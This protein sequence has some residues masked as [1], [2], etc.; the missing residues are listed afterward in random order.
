MNRTVLLA[1]VVEL[2]GMRTTPAG[3]PALD[4]SLGHSS[5][6]SEAGHPRKVSLEMRAVAIGT[7]AERLKTLAVG[8]TAGF[9]G[10]LG[11]ARNGKGV[12]LHITDF[13][14]R[15]PQAL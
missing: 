4:L 14:P 6:V 2:G 5:Q 12:L 3:V 8:D 9:T 13:E 1:Q 10:F 7:V 11:P 15:P